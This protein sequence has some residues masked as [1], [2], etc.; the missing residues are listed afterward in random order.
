[1]KEVLSASEFYQLFGSARARGQLI[2][3]KVAQEDQIPAPRTSCMTIEMTPLDW[4][5]RFEPVAKQILESRWKAKI[6]ELGRIR[7]PTRKGLAASPDGLILEA[8]SIELIGDLVEIKCPSS[9]EIGKAIPANYW[10]Q[11]QLQLEVTNRP[12]CQYCEFTFRSYT[13]QN[14]DLIEI[15]SRFEEKGILCLLQNETQL[16]TK[17]EY[18]PLGDMEWS[19]ILEEG[20][21]ILERVPWYLEKVWIQPVTRDE[22]WFQSLDVILEEFWSDVEKA[23][24][25][26][27][28]VPESSV[29]KKATICAIVD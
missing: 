18:G 11:M 24:K 9:R 4:G 5:I 14:R 16:Q 2:L 26:A 1:M 25:G 6:I 28:I 13:S 7:H 15:P 12:V 10:Y 29:K 22:A 19:P 27:F 21:E 3:S 20:W 8:E 17:Y 23:R